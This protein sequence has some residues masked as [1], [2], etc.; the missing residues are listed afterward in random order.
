MNNWGRR[1][2][3]LRILNIGGIYEC[4]TSCPGRFIPGEKAPSTHCI[5]GWMG[6][7]DRLD[8]VAETENP[9]IAPAGNRNTFVYL[10]A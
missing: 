2:I 1:R 8:A 3:A 7:R 10:V 6:P 9:I 4:S 5:G